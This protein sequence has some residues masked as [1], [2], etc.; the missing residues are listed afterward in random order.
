MSDLS[1]LFKPT[2]LRNL[3]A[4]NSNKMTFSKYALARWDAEA[5][6]E[7]VMPLTFSLDHADRRQ[8]A[9]VF[10]HKSAIVTLFAHLNRFKQ[11]TQLILWSGTP[12]TQKIGMINC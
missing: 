4:E 2:Y 10:Q 3:S 9:H 11:I 8:A 7:V 1:C 6:L 5:S 12:Q